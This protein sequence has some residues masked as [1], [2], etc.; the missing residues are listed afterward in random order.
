MTK[1]PLVRVILSFLL[2]AIAV[3]SYSPFDIW[4]LAYVSFI[5]LLLLI[6][7]KS[8]KK[9]AL[10]A[11]AWGLGYFLSGV[12]W[13]YVSINQYGDLPT[14]VAVIILS[15]LVAYLA[16]YPMIF[17]IMLR[18][19]N[20][21]CPAYS[22]K[23]FVI[24]APLVWQITEYLRSTLLNG[25]AWLQFGYS[26]LDSPLAGL[27]PIVGISG[28]NLIFAICCGFFAYLLHQ[29]TLH[30]WQSSK[31]KLPIYSAIC[32]ILVIF[33]A[34]FWFKFI[35]WTQT[36]LSRQTNVTLVQ[37]NIAQSLRWSSEQL[38]KTLDTYSQLTQQNIKDSD[39]IIWPEAT[40]TDFERNQQ[41]Y[42]MALDQY[43]RQNDTSVAVGIIDLKK[44]IDDYQIYNTLIILGDSVPYQYPTQN[45]YSKHHL[46]PFGEYIPLQSL[47]SPIAKMLNI[48]MSSM[49]AGPAIQKPLIMKGFKFSTVICYEVILSDL[50]WHNFTPDTD[51]LLTV[52]NDAWFGNSIGPWQH[53]Q[54]ART[55]ALEFGRTLLRSTNN[56]ITAIIT[57][58]GTIAKQLPQF[59]TT[60]LSITLN[61][62]IGL[63]PYARWGN[64][65]YY[66]LL[67]IFVII[68][69]VRRKNIK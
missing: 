1:S 61:P 20:N 31:N 57:P 46:V 32:T 19:L 14:L 11:F 49:S 53:L 25:F 6:Q 42:L 67:V 29:F 58:K 69:F 16:L 51:F 17:A 2:G 43:A 5:G 33:A 38:N 34:S 4:P 21:V 52:S 24:L 48:P 7:Q 37:G 65:P 54:M 39:I 62:N 36:D 55:R 22:L 10:I 40:I 45:R 56:G 8:I 15:L 30:G 35:N 26:Q 68:I 66:A 23:Q 13:V 3:L 50:L 27:F 60:T 9:T 63:T 64:Y 12:H 44:Q 28:V 59:Q 41:P 47:L 18:L